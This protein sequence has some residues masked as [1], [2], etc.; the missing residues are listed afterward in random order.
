MRGW[1]V[2]PRRNQGVFAS[3]SFSH[4]DPARDL[5]CSGTPGCEV[6]KDMRGRTPK[7]DWPE[8]PLAAILTHTTTA[9][10][11]ADA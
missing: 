5:S 1:R 11:E 3:A 8:D 4:V 7:H 6:H 10:M 9:Q 2:T